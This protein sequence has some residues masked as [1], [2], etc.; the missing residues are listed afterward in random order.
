MLYLFGSCISDKDIPASVSVEVSELVPCFALLEI[1]SGRLPAGLPLTYN[2]P[3]DPLPQFFF[4]SDA[5][6]LYQYFRAGSL[7]VHT[8]FTTT[9]PTAHKKQ[10]ALETDPTGEDDPAGHDTQTLALLAPVTPEYVPVGQFVHPPP[11]EYVPGI[12]VCIQT[13]APARDILPVSHAVHTVAPVTS[14]YVLTGQF[15]HESDGDEENIP[16]GH[17]VHDCRLS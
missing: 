4:G 11:D 12:Q 7:Y 2:T 5:S 17:A 6:N 10:F 15:T 1:T 9:C 8:P 3:P 13:L 14:E 16:E